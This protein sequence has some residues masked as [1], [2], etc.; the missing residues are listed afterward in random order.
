MVC[1]QDVPGEQQITKA[2]SQWY[3]VASKL[4]SFSGFFRMTGNVATIT[5]EVTRV[6]TLF[7]IKKGGILVSE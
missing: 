3:K 2:P 7:T 6:R 1:G 5:G 4:Q